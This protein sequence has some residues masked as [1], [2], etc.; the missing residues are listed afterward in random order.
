MAVQYRVYVTPLISAYVYGTEVEISDYVESS[1]NGTIDRSVDSTDFNIGVYTFSDIQLTCDNSDGVLSDASDSRSFFKAYSRDRAKVRIVYDNGSAQLIARGLISDPGT[2]VNSDTDEVTLTILGPDAVLKNSQI[3]VGTI[4][5][6]MTFQSALL[7]IL[8]TVD[9][10]SV[11]NVQPSNINPAL[12]WTIDDGSKYDNMNKYDA[13]TQLLGASNSVLLIDSSLNVIVRNRVQN[14]SRP[15]IYLYGKGDTLGRENILSITD[16]NTGVQRLFNSIVVKGGQPSSS[17]KNADGST[18]TSTPAA[19]AISLEE[20]DSNSISIYGLRQKQFTFEWLNQATSLDSVA[21]SILNE[22]RYPKIEFKVVVPTDQILTADLLDTVSVNYPFRVGPF[23]QFLPVIGITKIGDATAPLPYVKGALSIDPGLGFKIIQ[24][25][26]DVDTFQTTLKLRQ[27]GTTQNDGGLIVPTSVVKKTADYAITTSDDVILVD[28]TNGPVKITRPSPSAYPQK[29]Y[30]V[31]K[32][33]ATTNAV[34]IA[35]NGSD[36]LDGVLNQQIFV[37]NGAFQFIADAAQVNFEILN[38]VVITPTGKNFL[39]NSDFFWSQ[40]L[41]DLG[42]TTVANGLSTYIVDGWYVKNSLGTS[43]VI[44]GTHLAGTLQKRALKVQITTAPTVSPV[45]GCELYQTIENVESIQ[46][47]GQS[48]SFQIN[49]KA[50]GNVNQIGIQFFYKTTE[51][52]VDTAIGSEVTA[53]VTTG[54]LTTININGQALGTLQTT[55][56]VVGV[57]IRPTGVS[58]GNLYDLNNGFIVEQAI[59]NQGS[60]PATWTLQG[61]NHATE[62]TICMRHY[63]L[64]SSLHYTFYDGTGSSGYFLPIHFAVPKR[65][66]AATLD[67]AGTTVHVASAG[68]TDL[69]VNGFVLQISTNASAGLTAIGNAD[70]AKWHADAAI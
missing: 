24:I 6:G 54:A 43:G 9:I 37:Q 40:R 41:G 30:T 19:T 63:E 12:N 5:N 69:T 39:I 25:S 8:N 61:L 60:V 45:N 33:D 23:G 14:L 65:L 32:I 67:T 26:H 56:G 34:T 22:F 68:V 62:L 27:V 29:P 7:A 50:L 16:Y 18:T 57:R 55:S 53:S 3:S 58:S 44:T 38:E 42:N 17:T 47:Y 21:T 35:P 46:L 13:L 51:A 15:T 20:H 11:L 70:D 59:V 4:S 66:A 10:T 2:V 49:V 52:K 48:A 36:T 28:C 31:K 1:S 64:Q